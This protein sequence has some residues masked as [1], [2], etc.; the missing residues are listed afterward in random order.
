MCSDRLVSG[1]TN[2]REICSSSCVS[3]T[4]TQFMALWIVLSTRARL[5]GVCCL[6]DHAYI[7]WNN[8]GKLHVVARPFFLWTEHKGE[9]DVL[10]WEIID[11]TNRT[12]KSS[13][14]Y[15]LASGSKEGLEKNSIWINSAGLIVVDKQ[16]SNHTLENQ[17]INNLS[18]VLRST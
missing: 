14:L 4:N 8:S 10:N 1:E 18:T 17:K 5:D 2:I 12:Y 7:S 3:S 15:A 9:L 6:E 13:Q 16:A 11:T